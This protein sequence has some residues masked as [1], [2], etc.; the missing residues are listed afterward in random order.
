MTSA[1]I[2]SVSTWSLRRRY[3][4]KNRR[5][6]AVSHRP[7]RGRDKTEREG[8]QMEVLELSAEEEECR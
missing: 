6:Q 5:L 2:V 7:E 3:G 8:I 1:R 4:A